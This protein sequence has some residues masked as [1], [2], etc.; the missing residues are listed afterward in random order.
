MKCARR[1]R[2]LTARSVSLTTAL[3]AA[4][5]VC[6]LLPIPTAAKTPAAAPSSVTP[7]PSPSAPSGFTAD[8]VVQGSRAQKGASATLGV[9]VAASLELGAG[10]Q[11]GYVLNSAGK[12]TAVRRVSLEAPEAVSATRLYKKDGNTYYLLSWGRLA[13]YWVRTAAGT[14]LIRPTTWKVLVMVYRQTNLEFIDAS[15]TD[16]HL[17]ATMSAATESLMVGAVKSMP[18]LTRQWSSGVVVQKMTIVRPKAPLAR[19]TALGGGAYWLAP[20]DIA[21][22]L[23]VYAPTSSYD[24]I[25]VI[26]QPW[27]A[28]DY[29]SSWGWGLAF[30]GGPTSNGAAYSTVTVPPPGNSSWIT[31]KPHPGEPFMHEWL[32]GVID[33]QISNGS[34]TPDLHDNDRYGYVEQGGTWSRW[35]GDLMKQHVRDPLDGADVG[36]SYLDW[37]SGTIT[38][39]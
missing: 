2:A 29:I 26:W 28:E 25:M 38:S 5:F 1:M 10:P 36:I 7:F 12:R 33:Y 13:G 23:A 31:G 11:I 37:R 21:A 8:R 14:V 24:S 20:E 4:I 27:D 9:T 6:A 15:G 18:K 16:R 3:V 32:H 17:G 35:Y 39:L 34:G 30:A 19:L 22:D